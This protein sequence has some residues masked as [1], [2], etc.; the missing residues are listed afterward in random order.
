MSKKYFA[1]L[2]KEE[3]NSE[4]VKEM[5]MT[6]IAESYRNGTLSLQEAAT[7]AKVSIYEMM[8][9]TEK[10]Q[11]YPKELSDQEMEEHFKYAKK[12]LRKD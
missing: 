1:Q 3:M 2:K 8:E 11:I 9:F 4:K 5:R 10:H 7:A 6:R 12:I